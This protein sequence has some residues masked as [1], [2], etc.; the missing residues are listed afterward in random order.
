[1]WA[2]VPI[3]PKIVRLL[4]IRN[5][6]LLTMFSLSTSLP[7]YLSPRTPK[8]PLVLVIIGLFLS[9]E[10]QNHTTWVLLVFVTHFHDRIP[11][12]TPCDNDENE[13]GRSS[14]MTMS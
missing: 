13:H 5:F 14:N 2:I 10:F 8:P 9:A 4:K 1:M 3:P 11:T 7:T 6:I 12:A